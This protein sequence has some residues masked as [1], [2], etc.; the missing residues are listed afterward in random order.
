ML[1]AGDM[2]DVRYGGDFKGSV[3][4]WENYKNLEKYNPARHDLLANWK[5]PMMVIHSDLD[6]RCI[7]SGGLA[8]FSVCQALGTPSK[9]LNFPDEVN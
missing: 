6:Y 3:L 1:I 7:L 5:T 8:A 4:P 9:F 2:I